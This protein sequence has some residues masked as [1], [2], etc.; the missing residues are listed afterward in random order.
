VQRVYERRGAEA[1]P[2]SSTPFFTIP[3]AAWVLGGGGLAGMRV[4]ANFGALGKI[5]DDDLRD[6][7]APK[8]HRARRAGHASALP[9]GR[10]WTHRGWR[11]PRRR[12]SGLRGRMVEHAGDD[13]VPSCS[14]PAARP[15]AFVS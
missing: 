4:F 15:G 12:G 10:H 7:C 8:L 6:R 11:I 5:Q 9:R 14:D 2:R 1:L 13:P 3:T